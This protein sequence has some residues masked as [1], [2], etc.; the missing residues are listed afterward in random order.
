MSKKLGIGIIGSGGIA[1]GCHMKSYAALPDRCE[2]VQVCDVNEDVA[3]SAAAEFGVEN[4]TTDYRELLANPAIDAVSVATPNKFHLDPT[5]AAL[6]AGKHV[7]CEKPLGMNADECRQMCAAARDSGKILQVGLQQRFTG[8]A[9]FLKSYIDSGQMGDV[10]YARAQALRR[11]GV[12]G[13]GV[14]IDKEKQGGGPLIDI[15]VHI[16]D[17]TLFLMGYPKPVMALGSTYDHLGKNPD[18]YNGFG[19]YDRSKFTVEDFAVA[20][21]KF[22]NGATVVLESSFMANIA[23]QPL[24]SQLMGTKSG[25]II[26]SSGDEPIVLY[27]E[28]EKQLFDERPANIPRVDNPY[29]A[30]VDAFLKAI[31]TGGPSPVPGE[32]GLILNAIFDAIYRSSETGREEPIDVTF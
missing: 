9:R 13:W 25:A 23:D 8:P 10:Y 5:V 31:E 27:S 15:G 3:R 17:L 7:L 1:R 21:V 4:V 29:L 12:P 2:I 19:D 24:T 30:E 32:N 28:R 18:I 6:K 20:L 11:R 22:E 14:F 26:R 16:L